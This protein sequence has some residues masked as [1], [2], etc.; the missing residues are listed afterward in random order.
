M[1]KFNLTEIKKAYENI[2]FNTAI[3]EI[4]QQKY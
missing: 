1:N 2:S 4:K 3:L